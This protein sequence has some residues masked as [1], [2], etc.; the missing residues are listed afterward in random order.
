MKKF[1]LAAMACTVLSIVLPSIAIAG[2]SGSGTVSFLLGVSTGHLLFGTSVSASH[3]A[4]ATDGWAFDVTTPG[5]KMMAALLV[6]A[7][8]SG[9]QVNIAGAGACDVYPG[10]ETVVYVVVS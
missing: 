10:R 9:K 5:G 7:Q 2:G 8:A 3:P 6:S 4:C 1:A